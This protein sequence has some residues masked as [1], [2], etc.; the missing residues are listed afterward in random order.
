M[1]WQVKPALIGDI[2]GTE[3]ILESTAHHQISNQ[4]CGGTQGQTPN[5]V[6]GYG[7]IN[8]PAAAR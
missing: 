1:L 2:D 3:A 7:I 8:L 5:N 4:N 6:F